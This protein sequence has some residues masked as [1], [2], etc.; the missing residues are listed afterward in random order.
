MMPI[1]TCTIID[2]IIITI[3][4]MNIISSISTIATYSAYKYVG[5]VVP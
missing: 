2:T 4:G 3:V 5:K 1:V